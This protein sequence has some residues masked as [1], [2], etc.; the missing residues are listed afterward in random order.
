[1]I[2]CIESWKGDTLLSGKTIPIR[3]LKEQMRRAESLCDP[4]EDNFIPLLIRIY[5]WEIP[6]YPQDT[7][8]DYTYDRD[9]GLILHHHY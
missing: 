9:T 8:P 6:P 2:I 3:E 7:V 1:M 5:G 4:A